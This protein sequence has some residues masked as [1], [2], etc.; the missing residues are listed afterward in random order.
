MRAARAASAWLRAPTDTEAYSRLVEAV[1]RWEGY[2][3][4]TLASEDELLDELAEQNP[5]QPLGDVVP[6]L[7]AALR[8]KARLKL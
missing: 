3:S 8:R 6:E 1:E 2:G 7:E 4:P 5:P